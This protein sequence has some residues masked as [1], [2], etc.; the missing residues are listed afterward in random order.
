VKQL[1]DPTAAGPLWAAIDRAIVDK[2][3]YLW[4]VNPITVEFVSER[5]DNYQWSPQW[6]SELLNQLWVQ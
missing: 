5:V 1:G 3:P 4:M 6:G 2:A